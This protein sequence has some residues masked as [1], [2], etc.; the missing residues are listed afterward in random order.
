MNVLIK[1]RRC[2]VIHSL[3][4]EVQLGNLFSYVIYA[5]RIPRYR[6]VL[7]ELHPKPLAVIFNLE[8]CIFKSILFFILSFVWGKNF[9][10]AAFFVSIEKSLDGR[11]ES[12]K[13]NG[14]YVTQNEITSRLFLFTSS[15]LCVSTLFLTRKFVEL[16]AKKLHIIVRTS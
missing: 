5:N 8:R 2:L 10:A 12:V 13:Y 11:F 7:F 9:D 3:C 16:H 1:V 6:C 14:S 4:W 15:L